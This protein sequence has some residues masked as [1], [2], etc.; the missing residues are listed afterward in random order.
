[1]DEPTATLTGHETERLFE[2]IDTLKTKGVSVIY[3]SHRTE[4]IRRVA[5]RVTVLRDGEQIIT[6]DLA[7]IT[8]QEIIKHMVGREVSAKY[9][10]EEI[11]AGAELLRVENMSKQGVCEKISFSLHQG[12]IL[13]VAGL[14]G[15]G[16]TEMI[17]L[18]FGYQ[19]R[20]SGAITIKGKPL[21]IKTPQMRCA[22]AWD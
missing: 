1:M 19:K 7:Q 9:P 13:G 20:H 8:M 6:T 12:E 11:P 22:R 5:N 15:A 14:V 21:P 10:K 18:L 4:E 3:I 2:M 17:Q 16:R